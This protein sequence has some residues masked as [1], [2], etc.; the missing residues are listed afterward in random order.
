MKGLTSGVRPKGLPVVFFVFL[1]LPLGTASAHH[2]RATTYDDTNPAIVY[3]QGQNGD[4]VNG[5]GTG[6]DAADFGGGEHYSNAYS[7]SFVV[8]FS[9]T[10]FQWI[11]KKGPN[12]GIASLFLDGQS[13]GTVDAYSPSVLH[14]QVLYSTGGLANGAHVFQMK[15][16]TYP[17]PAKNPASSNW[18]Q[19]MD[20]F[21]TSGT[22]LNLKM[23]SPQNASVTKAGSWSFGPNV[24]SGAYCWSNDRS[25]PAS[26][27]LPFSG[28]GVEVY[29]HPEGED[30]MMDVYIDGSYVTTVDQYNPLLDGI[31]SDATN[32]TLLYAKAGLPAGN[33]SL[34]LVVSKSKNPAA[35]DYYTQIDGFIVLPASGGGGGGGGIVG[36]G[37]GLTG[38]YYDNIDFTNLKV[39]RTDATV[40][41]DWGSGSPDPSI[42]PDTF[43]ARWTGQVQAQFGETYTF[44][45][46]S[47]DGI[48]LWVNGVLVIN[49]WTD[50][51]PTEDSGTISLSA[52]TKVSLKLEYYENGGGAVSKLL[53][54]SPSTSKQVVPQSQLYPAAT[55]GGSGGSLSGMS[56]G[57]SG[58]NLTSTGTSDWA[59]WDGWGTFVHKSSGGGQLSNAALVGSGGNYGGWSDASR[60][61][62][63]SDG[64]PIVSGTSSSYIWS[65]GALGTGFQV[66]APADAATRS[67]T[68]YFGAS[69]AT[70]TLSAHLSDG[71]AADYTTSFT[72]PGAWA[73]TITYRAA[74]A[75]QILVLK[76]LKTGNNAG[77]TNG[78]ADLIAAMLH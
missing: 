27:T 57:S 25:T 77:F 53:W 39:T 65:N 36:N 20:G 30:G 40:N 55:G 66:T 63:W 37:T 59:Y 67:V 54:S 1:L 23:I 68:V 35:S 51:A 61:V 31:L 12:F 29:G 19:V 52:G 56:G 13:V 44:Y 11:G 17:N 45:T 6:S 47:D 58:F 14:Q 41:F 73:A 64:T 7:G 75:G 71:S 18:Y 72:G 69:T 22:P 33:H 3:S 10:D 34:R 24:L 16:G 62:T 74:S 2:R 26:L 49:N 28:T 38:Q 70:C 5:W 76:L 9:G 4:G 21:A 8:H 15:I 50:H 43:S 48:R 42:G 60:S 78:S 46:D 32:D